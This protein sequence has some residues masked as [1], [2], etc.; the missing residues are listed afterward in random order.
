MVVGYI[1]LSRRCERARRPRVR[2]AILV[3]DALGRE[4]IDVRRYCVLVAIAAQIGACILAAQP[5]NVRLLALLLAA[6]RNSRQ[7]HRPQGPTNPQKPPPVN[8]I[9]NTSHSNYP[10]IFKIS[11]NP[12]LSKRT[13]TCKKG[14][15]CRAKQEIPMIVPINCEKCKLKFWWATQAHFVE[16]SF[17]ITPDHH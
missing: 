6:K 13:T 5:Q 15:R 3:A 4:I 14:R 16:N 7:N 11:Y 12:I 1:P 8:S 9:P 2:E 10:Q 17:L